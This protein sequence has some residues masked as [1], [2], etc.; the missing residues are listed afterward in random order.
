M[1]LFDTNP[2]LPRNNN[3][4]ICTHSWQTSTIESQN[5][6]NES[7]CVTISPSQFRPLLQTRSAAVSFAHQILLFVLEHVHS[8]KIIVLI[9]DE[10][11]K[12]SVSVFEHKN[13]KRSLEMAIAQ[14]QMIS[15]FFSEACN[16]LSLNSS[17]QIKIICW[18][19]MLSSSN[20]NLRVDH[21]RQYIDQNQSGCTS[22]I[23][24]VRE[25]QHPFVY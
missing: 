23:D 25:K 8:S 5:D 15:G 10:I 11:Q 7:V 19:D 18:T 12:Y 9:A 16:Q 14:G 4:V 21:I 20:Y 6:A 13:E 2:D 1:A 3:N 22:L 24:Q 17:E